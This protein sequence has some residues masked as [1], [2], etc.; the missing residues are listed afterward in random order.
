MTPFHFQIPLITMVKRRNAEKRDYTGS[1]GIIS[2][3]TKDYRGSVGCNH[4]RFAVFEF[5]DDDLH[6]ETESRKTLAKFGTKSPGKKPAHHLQSMDKYT[7]LQFFAQGTTSQQKNLKRDVLDVDVTDSASQNTTFWTDTRTTPSSLNYYHPSYSLKKQDFE[8]SSCSAK[9]CGSVCRKPGGYTTGKKHDNV[10]YVD[11]DED[12]R[13]D[14]RSS[15]SFDLAENEGSLKESKYGANDNDCEAVVVVAPH[16]VTYENMHYR[17]CCLTFSQRFIRLE[18]SPLHERT[19]TFCFEWPTFDILKIEYQ[20][21][22]SVQA[23]IVNIY[24]KSKD[25]NVNDAV[26]GNSGSVE[27]EFVVLDDPQWSEKLEDIK[28][29][30]LK[31]KAAWE[32]IISECNLD[33]SFEDMTY[34]DG[35]P[36]AVFISRSDV[37]LLQPGTFINDTIIDFYIKY[38]VNKTDPEKQRRFHFFNTFFFQKLLDMR[39]DLSETWERSDDFQRVRKWT[40]NVN[41]FEKDYIFIPVNLSLHWSLIVIC[42]PGEVANLRDKGMDG[43]PTIPCILHMDSIRGSHGGFENLIRR[44]LWEEWKEQ[45]NKQEEDILKKLLT[46]DFITLQL[47]QQE[48]FFDCGIF[49][50]H[51]AE[52]FLEQV[53]N[54]IATKYVDFLNEDWFIAVE[55]SLK[56]RD[57]I[58]KLIHR[59]AKEYSVNKDPPAAHNNQHLE[60]GVNEGDSCSDSVQPYDVKESP[61]LGCRFNS[62]DDFKSKGQES[63]SVKLGRNSSVIDEF[64][65]YKPQVPINQF[66]P[67]EDTIGNQAAFPLGESSSYEADVDDSQISTRYPI[68]SFT[69][70][71]MKVPQED[72]SSK[73]PIIIDVQDE[74]DCVSGVASSIERWE[75]N[76]NS[77]MSNEDLEACIIEDSEEESETES[78][79]RTR[80]SS[81]LA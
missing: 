25:M 56:K 22:G 9:S 47:P 68:T 21:C 73:S 30:D 75:K 60:S 64:Q 44:Y 29:L 18:G 49:L 52:L 71:K 42:H 6:I 35:D 10:L 45:G 40:R 31:Y 48:N 27:L 63:F 61:R 59:I 70:A 2:S 1:E 54:S 78:L 23:N 20:Q 39:R 58:K 12:G 14:L 81:Y 24:L 16:Y 74:Q 41:I 28:S 66:M 53:S 11:S 76:Y 80:K 3:S 32:T 51:Y 77:S 38:L 36:D 65:P 50:L 13:M 37:E 4:N 55:V 72:S 15:S 43:S 46:L 7:F 19:E 5:A 62:S 33:E 8:Y 17:R 79:V 67:M 57:H 26:E 34:P 69:T